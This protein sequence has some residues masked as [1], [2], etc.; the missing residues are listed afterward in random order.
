MNTD[1]D[2]PPQSK[3]PSPQRHRDREKT[4]KIKELL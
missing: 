2:T 4:V 1:N 3:N